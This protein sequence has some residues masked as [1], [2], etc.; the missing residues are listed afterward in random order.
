MKKQLPPDPDG[1]NDRR[2]GWAEEAVAAFMAA[3]GTD[4][5]NAICDLLAD[6]M[7]LCDR[8]GQDFERQLLRA[9]Y[10]YEAE[11]TADS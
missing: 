10:H 7:H 4:L 5:D 8:N 11:T 2:A 9:E 3:S 6:L 1:M